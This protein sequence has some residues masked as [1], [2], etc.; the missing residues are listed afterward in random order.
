MVNTRKYRLRIVAVA[1]VTLFAAALVPAHAASAQNDYGELT[2]RWWT[3]VYAQPADERRRHEHQPHPGL[4]GAVRCQWARARD[5]AGQQ[6]LLPHRHVRWHR[7]S[8]CDGTEG[9]GLVLPDHQR[10]GR[11]RGRSADRQQGAGVEG[12][13]QGDAST[14]RRC[15]TP[16]SDGAPVT[17]FRS[18]S[19]TFDY[20][21]PDE[22]TIY[23]YFGLVGPQFEG[24]GQ[25]GSGRRLL[26]L[27][28]AAGSRRP[29]AQVPERELLGVHARRHV[30]PDHRLG[31]C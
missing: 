12:E 15:C 6:V 27:P 26:G 31:G 5:R 8:R 3:W 9:Q 13:R 10:R 24:P 21:L 17:I 19:P 23:D 30:Q 22:N 1:T 18:T 28:A 14:R 4:D 25:A 7:R 11:Q 20:T 2:A 29:R 16:R